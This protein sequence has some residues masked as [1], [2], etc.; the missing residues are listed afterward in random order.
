MFGIVVL[1][2]AVNNILHKAVKLIT[3]WRCF[4]FYSQT[5]SY[6]HL[7]VYS[8]FETWKLHYKIMS[9]MVEM[10]STPA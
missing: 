4:Y 2:E 10:L 7:H 1:F 8:K 6:H 9:V 5:R 3:G